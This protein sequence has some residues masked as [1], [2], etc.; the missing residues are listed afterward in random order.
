MAGVPFI[1]TPFTRLTRYWVNS[2]ASK[3]YQFEHDYIEC[4]THVGAHRAIKDCRLYL[5]DMIE[6]SKGTKQVNM[7]DFIIIQHSF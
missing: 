7:Y 2:Q 1:N 4:A 6:C 5:E 3:C